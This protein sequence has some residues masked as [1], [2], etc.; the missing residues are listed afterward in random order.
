MALIV[1]HVLI[2]IKIAKTLHHQHGVAVDEIAI[3][4]PYSAQKNKILEM[5]KKL[6]DELCK[7]RVASITESQ[8]YLFLSNSHSALT[9]FSDCSGDEYGIVILS[10]V[11]SQPLDEIKHKEYIQPDRIWRRENLG[12]ICDTHQINVGITRSK[13]GLVI[14]GKYIDSWVKGQHKQLVKYLVMT[15]PHYNS[16]WLCCPL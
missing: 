14:T 2:Q 1:L 9:T 15:L 5:V 11:R 10:T 13:R 8:G 3:M 4:S 12:F 7:L 6:P 16:T